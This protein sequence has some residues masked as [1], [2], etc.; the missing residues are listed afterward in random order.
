MKPV[1]AAPVLA[2]LVVGSLAT[3]CGGAASGTEGVT[4]D[5]TN[6]ARIAPGTFK[7]YDKPRAVPYASCDVHTRLELGADASGSKAKLEEAKAGSCALFVE[8][9][10]R[11]YDLRLAESSCGSRIYTGSTSVNGASFSVKVTDHR[12][13]VCKDVV[14]AAIIVEESGPA[15]GSPGPK[16]TTRYSTDAAGSAST[17]TTATVEGALQKIEGADGG[18]AKYGIQTA[19]GPYELV[20]DDAELRGFVDGRRARVSGALTTIPGMETA[21]H[22]L[23]DVKSML[24][25]PAA[26]TLNCM[27]RLNLP[28]ADACKKDNW[29]WVSASCP[30]VD[31]VF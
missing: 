25:C 30:G 26:G 7:L 31:V 10:P 6:T 9:N 11:A 18:G 1:S 27:P 17:V 5:Q 2:V 3:A 4:E 12:A 16:T 22:R 24:V 14:P 20:L 29:Q 19:D 15:P 13:R 21:E 28:V 23:I 8:A